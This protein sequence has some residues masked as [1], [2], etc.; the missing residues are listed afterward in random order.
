M[1][2]HELL[3]APASHFRDEMSCVLMRKVLEL[4]VTLTLSLLIWTSNVLDYTDGG[5]QE[6]DAL[7]TMCSSFSVEFRCL[8][9]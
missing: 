1:F 9:N 3:K 7:K 4:L 6:E 5:V 8:D 2:I